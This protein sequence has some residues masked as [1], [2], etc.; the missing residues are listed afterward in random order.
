MFGSHLALWSLGLLLALPVSVS[1]QA[2][3]KEKEKS[4]DKASTKLEYKLPEKVSELIQDRNYAQAIKELEA[5]IKEPK[6]QVDYLLYHQARAHHLSQQYDE[7]IKLFQ[8]VETEF[9]TS[10]WAKR[11]RLSR[12]VSLARK[13]DFR[14]AEVIY[15][16]EAKA[17]LSL[18]RKQEIANIYLEFADSYFQPKDEIA[19]KPDYNKA[20]EFYR[21][22]LAVG[23]KLDSAA[24]I[25]LRIARCLQSLNKHNEAIAAYEAYLKKYALGKEPK[26]EEKQ[27]IIEA[28]YRLGQVQMDAGQPVPARR[29]WQDLL[30]LHVDDQSELIPEAAYQL[31]RTWNLPNPSSKEDLSLGISAWEKFL[32][33]YPQHKLAPAAHLGIARSY[34]NFGRSAEA[35]KAL[36]RFLN[37]K[38]YQE[39]PEIADARNLL[40]QALLAQKKFAEA[41]TAWR[42]YL[43]K[44]PAHSAWNEVQQGIVNAE[45]LRADDARANKKWNDARNLWDEFL[46]KYPLDGRIPRIMYFY[47]QMQ[48]EDQKWEAA[49]TEWRK[50]V[51][52]YPNTNEASTAQYMIG[53]TLEQK[54]DKLSAALEEFKKVTQGNAVNLAKMSISRLTT[55]VMQISTTRTFR[56]GEKPTIRLQSRNIDEVTLRCYRIDLETYFRKMHLIRGIEGLDIALIDPDQTTTYKVPKY[57]EYQLFENQVPIELPALSGKEN[58][59]PTTGAMAVTVNSKTLEATTLLV[60]SNL[61][62]IVK[63]S[64]EEVL[65]FAQNLQTGKPWPKTKLL[66]SDGRTVFAEVATGEDGIYRGTFKELRETNELRVFATVDGHVA[67]NMLSMNGLSNAQGLADTGLIY[68]DRPAYRAGQVVHVRGVIRRAVNDEFVLDADKK[69]RVNVFDPR[70]R[71]VWSEE[72]TLTAFGS[73]RTLFTLPS[74]SPSGQYRVMVQDREQSGTIYNGGFLVQDYNLEPI[75]LAVDLPR[76]IYYRGEEITGKIVAKY[77]YGAPI[78]NKEIRYQLGDDR[79]ETARTN[80]NG[81]VSFKFPTRELRD[82]QV[83]PVIAT[84]TE[85]NL[86]IA[87]NVVISSQGFSIEVK[88]PRNVYLA[89]E[90]WESTI[91]TKD[92][93][94]KPIAQK[95]KLTLY[96]QNIVGN[97]V[98]EVE[99]SS[100]EI[101]TDAKTGIIRKTFDVKEGGRYL[102]RAEGIDRF[103]N[104]ISGQALV[105]I[106]DDQDRVRL[107]ILGEKFTGDVG[108]TLSMNINWR[109]PP[110]L[111]LVTFQGARILEYRLLELKTG[112]N[113]FA[114]PLTAKLAPNFELNVSLMHDA[115]VV[116][117]PDQ[118]ADVDQ[119]TAKEN[120]SAPAL[121][122]H[123]ASLGIIVQ[124]QLKVEIATERKGNAKGELRPGEEVEL[125]IKT[126]DATGKPLSAELSVAMIEQSLLNMFGSGASVSDVFQGAWRQSAM[127]SNSSINFEYRP[128]TRAIDTQLLAEAERREIAG[129]EAALRANGV[130]FGTV[131]ANSDSENLSVDGPDSVEMRLVP[132]LMIQAEDKE[133]MGTHATQEFS[134]KQLELRSSQLNEANDFAS[135]G[136]AQGGNNW[137]VSNY[138]ALTN[139]R[140]QQLT[141]GQNN[142]WAANPN[143]YSA[144]QLQQAQQSAALTGRNRSNPNQRFSGKQEEK[145][146]GQTYAF[147]SVERASII[148]QLDARDLP[149][150][151]N[152]N[153]S[154]STLTL[155]GTNTYTGNN[156]YTGQTLI[157]GGTLNLGEANTLALNTSISNGRRDI[158]LCNPTNGEQFNF[159]FR[160]N[161]GDRFDVAM[162]DEVSKKLA[163]AGNLIM[164]QSGPQETGY[165]NPMIVTD[166]TGTA[167]LTITMPDQSTAWKI[168][169]R[170]ITKETLAGQAEKELIVKQDLFGELKLPGSLT[171]GDQ[172]EVLALVHNQLLDQGDCEV[173]L[174]AIIGGKT[175]EEKKPIKLTG[176]GIQEVPFQFTITRPAPDPEKADALVQVLAAFELTVA[177]N[178]TSDVVRRVVPVLPYGVPVYSVQSGTA[179]GDSTIWI[180]APPGLPVQQPQL[181]VVIGSSVDRSLFDILLGAPLPCGMDSLRFSAGLDVTTSDLMAALALQKLFDKTR[182][183]HT[184]QAQALDNRIRAAISQLVSAQRDD[185]AWSWS[186]HGQAD[187]RLTSARVYWALHLAIKSG[188]KVSDEALQKARAYLEKQLATL[189]ETDYE[190]RAVVLHALSVAGQADFAQANR[191]HRN[192]SLLSPTALVYTALAFTEMDRKPVAN[193]LIAALANEA[194]LVDLP[195]R[196]GSP[197]GILPWSAS[198]IELRALMALAL[199]KITPED[200][201]LKEQV[202]WLMSQRRGH[203]WSPE[204]ATG[205]ATLVICD[206]YARAK[207]ETEKY[208]LTLFVNDLQVKQLTIEKQAETVTVD[209]PAKLLKAGKNRVN[210]QLTGRGRYTYQAIL[211]GYVPADKLTNT[212]K[213]WSVLRRYEQA[214]RELD[215]RELPR[216]FDVLSGS[217][218]TFRNPMTQVAVGQRGIVTLEVSRY[219]IPANTPEDQLDYLVVT[220]P[221][222]S[223]VSVVESSIK[224]G[225]ERFELGAGT[226]TFYVGTRHYMDPIRFEVHGYL[227]GQYRAAPTMVRN[228]YRLDDLAVSSVQSLKVL[229]LGGKSADPYR[230]TPRELFEYGQRLF[231]KQD[232]TAALP[233]LTELFNKWTLNA[234]TYQKTVLMLFETHLRLGPAGDVVRY[235]EIIKERYPDQEVAFDKMLSVAAAY[236]KLGEYE[237]S[238]MVYRAILENNF[239]RENSVAGYLEQQG[240]FL[241]SVEVMQRLLAE[242]PPEP[243]AAATLYGLAQRVYA[244][245]PRA[246]SDAKLREKKINRVTLIQQ[247]LGMLDNFI[248]LYP[249]DP[250]ADQASFS[251]ANALLE[252]E[253][254]RELIRRSTKYAERYPKSEYLDSFWYLVAYGHF[255]LQEHEAA[256]KMARQV[257]ETK[258]IDPATGREIESPN[259]WQAVYILG[260]VHHS[261]G[262]ASEAVK[263]YLRVE[264]RFADAKEAIAYFL[265]KDI[266]LP[267]VTTLKPDAKVAVELTFRNIPKIDLKVYR[268]DLMKFSLLKRNL[269]G[270]T[271]INLAGIRPSH[272]ATV[273]LGNGKDYRDRKHEL[274]IPVKEEGAYLVVCR[275][276]SLHASGLILISPLTVEVAEEAGAGRVRVTVKDSVKDRYL[277][278]VQT[279]VIGSHNDEFVSGESD[280]RGVFI[281]DKINGKSTVIAQT[282]D[283]RYAFFRGNQELGT[284]PAPV[285]APAPTEPNQA[286]DPQ[287]KPGKQ[288]GADDQQKDSV[289]IEQLQ[290]G[291]KALQQRWNE[292]LDNNYKPR[293]DGVKAKSAF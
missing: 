86:R 99:I 18:E 209:V 49:I 134:E 40:G 15:Q 42:D 98:G 116:V 206:Y 267:E 71:N 4:N 74:T 69:Y 30:A 266:Q 68:T 87:E 285:A 186:G 34:L 291:N 63:S 252:L 81:E 259:K 165:W 152:L 203:R 228:A 290:R 248:T 31:A 268:I 115:P 195:T 128:T 56:T 213:E 292:N 79:I 269:G 142:T 223:G 41:I 244:Y 108:Q 278:K 198:A 146:N 167:T 161:L 43:A 217:Y 214:Q 238:Y 130:A 172:I 145:E 64:R 235:F 26:L 138:F 150:W 10:P 210:L 66:L 21:Q 201:K 163:S 261:L 194:A 95:L 174:K 55:K 20:L 121:R 17:I 12:A 111:A 225:F 124:R 110:A 270:I 200:P 179:S 11:S 199:A 23:V 222:P 90:A 48:F 114:I 75:Q 273:E 136:Q 158:M 247:A 123:E 177:V 171:D 257:A 144:Q 149:S 147:N 279:K 265:R 78:V 8:R 227:P 153:K 120:D 36:E 241:R 106:S 73:L 97:Q 262:Q 219:N 5:A 140:V 103:D 104:T 2:E 126:T 83:L 19:V 9:K 189:A 113:P 1:A 190:S 157:N 61:E 77:Y 22:A 251:L 122:Y 258:R 224:G 139:D 162:I 107:R 182:D 135:Q 211:S 212:T 38:D 234:D 25:E 6:A 184:V 221:L 263:E 277:S 264:D 181:Q 80:E 245:A 230:L 226:I 72:V 175:L 32:K 14:A 70:N 216:G 255:A 173:T 58:A 132:G 282:E 185:G 170:G 168:I 286:A 91:T 109:N 183:A 208:Q 231:N 293:N 7:A 89:G 92:A 88:Q 242:Y 101:T 13:G 166:E 44:H 60:Q 35:I 28:R 47:G 187:H 39:K 283:G 243:Y 85:R 131:L 202:D 271:Q 46:T 237:R 233:H 62:I 232:Y 151:N 289:L 84:Y 192:K 160:N 143:G 250:A 274:E 156:T 94:G 24:T 236:D 284:P 220:E 125:K 33:T 218:T 275:G 260:Q 59:A 112:N 76:R 159:N 57:A 27:R 148:P 178:E 65:V 53:I 16:A 276:E 280:L 133:L 51:A 102:V 117:K 288:S 82:S 287:A 100:A 249:D 154:N 215:G 54:L 105:Q 256:L 164:D 96:K 3:N 176:K 29:T 118:A 137:G 50:L 45:Y 196:R 246:I 191:L 207:F 93:E 52:K 155:N 37:A 229:P 127:L 253:A 197:R 129:E 272:E 169:T 205:P 204:K 119:P 180:E 240:E 188:Y 254:H 281:A 193:E 141:G 67:S 239:L